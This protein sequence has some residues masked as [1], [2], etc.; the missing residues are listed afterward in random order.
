MKAG[1]DVMKETR[2]QRENRTD[3]VD[4]AQHLA[5]RVKKPFRAVVI[6]TDEAGDFVGVGTN[7]TGDDAIAIMKCALYAEGLVYRDVDGEGH[8]RR[9]KRRSSKAPRTTHATP[10]ANE[11]KEK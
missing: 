2:K 11:A 3:L 6:V 4:R 5:E 7:T 10:V 8:S 1:Y 9:A